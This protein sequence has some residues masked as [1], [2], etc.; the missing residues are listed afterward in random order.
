ME[1]QEFA[2]QNTSEHQQSP[3]P[4]E[5][6]KCTFGLD[7]CTFKT[8]RKDLLKV[9]V[10]E[11]HLKILKNCKHCGK[12]MTSSSLSRHTRKKTCLKKNKAADETSKKKREDA[13]SSTIHDEYVISHEENSIV[14][15]QN[16]N[17][18][19]VVD[20][21]NVR[22]ETEISI[23]IHS[24]GKFTVAHKGI[25]IGDLTLYLTTQKPEGEVTSNII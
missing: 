1:Q 21:K 10:N 17:R 18:D 9:H 19:N 12:S 15:V 23:A 14:S 16:S 20:V 6:Y 24:D 4:Q 25:Q 13:R 8:D 3:Q 22:I 7:S 2:T 5:V 11:T